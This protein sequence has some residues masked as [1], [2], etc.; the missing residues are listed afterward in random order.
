MQDKS[1]R[2][3]FRWPDSS[4]RHSYFAKTEIEQSIP[5]RFQSQV[6]MHAERTAISDNGQIYSYEELN[7]RSNQVAH[8]ILEALDSGEEPA[9]VLLDQGTASIIAILG[10]LKAGKFYVPLDPFLSRSELGQAIA[11]CRP[12]LLV[13]DNRHMS[14]ATDLVSPDGICL[15]IEKVSA[16]ARTDNPAVLLEPTRPAYIFYTSG[17]TGSPKGVVDCHRNVLHNVLRYTN[18]LGITLDDRLSLIQSCSFSGTVSSLFSAVL[19]GATVC[20]FDLHANGI[21]RLANWVD[22]EQITIF[23]SVPVI[24]EQLIAAGGHFRSLRL[25]R[26]EG[27]QPHRR[28]IEMFQQK[29]KKGCV[30]VNGLG[31]TETGII[32]QYFIDSELPLRG[33]V[34]PVGY[35]VDDMQIRLLDESGAP[36]PPGAIGEITVQSRYLAEGYWGRKALTAESFRPDLDDV[37]SRI[38]ATGD[39]GRFLPDGCLE[40]LGRRDSRIKL[41]GRAIEVARIENALCELQSVDRA[42]VVAQCTG[43]GHRQLVA[44]MVAAEASLPSV[45]V[46]RRSLAKSLP[47]VMLPARYVFLTELPVDRHNKVLRRLLP[48]PSRQRPR[49]DQ[50]FVAPKSRRQ[51]AIANCFSEILGIDDVGIHDDFFE[52]GGDSLMAAEVLL[53]IEKTLGT[54]CPAGFLFHERSVAAL[55]RSIGDDGGQEI[56]VAIKPTGTRVPLFCLHNHAGHILEYRRLAQLL[57]ADQPVFGVQSARAEIEAGFTLEEMAARYVDEIQKVQPQ[58]PYYLCGNCFGGVVAFEVAQ[59]LRQR[60]E[61]VALLALIDTAFPVGMMQSILRR[62]RVS[63][64]A[65]GLPRLSVRER[66]IRLLGKLV[67][68]CVW[69]L[70]QIKRRMQFGMA[71]LLKKFRPRRWLESLDIVAFHQEI[72]KRYRPKEYGGCVALFCILMKDNQLPWKRIAKRGVKIVQLTIQESQLGNPHL[73][74][75]PYVSELASELTKLLNARDQMADQDD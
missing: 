49:L 46:L 72:E 27:D 8:T 16:N 66:F 33:D 1:P 20:P 67:R 32:R 52:L 70:E 44:Y 31:T 74:D 5:D 58:G 39:L 30:L 62:L 51:Q 42:I 37:N 73:V 53:R 34:V 47:E 75:D 3:S 35:P 41:R 64:S 2:D 25:I 36:V 55:D 38:Y 12:R 68:F 60:D 50:D 13:T 11:D 45:G 65:S 4:R 21:S 23:H 43:G 71:R 48:R 28:H 17:S 22:Q 40:Y 15:N 18:N 29:F 19:N 63:G 14:L 56:I 61:D 59:Q 7:A 10:I 9:V 26:V 54:P 24:F 6:R 69:V 57:G